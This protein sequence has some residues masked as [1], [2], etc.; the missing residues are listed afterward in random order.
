MAWRTK[1]YQILI[2]HFLFAGILTFMLSL[3][4]PVKVAAGLA[5]WG[6]AFRE[7]EQQIQNWHEKNPINAFDA[8][9]D[10]AVPAVSSVLVWLW[11][12]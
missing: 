8:V 7:C 1:G 11:L 6:Y 12:R 10:V 4:V 3:V 9:L 2:N 5:I